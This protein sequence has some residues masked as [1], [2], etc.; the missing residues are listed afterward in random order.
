MPFHFLL[1]SK[2]FNSSISAEILRISRISSSAVDFVSR[3]KVILDRM[4]E[5]G[6]DKARVVKSLV[7]KFNSHTNDLLHIAGQS[8]TFV[9]LIL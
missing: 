1:P 7:K 8:N 2:I 5:Q 9:A 6:S 3:S 4:S